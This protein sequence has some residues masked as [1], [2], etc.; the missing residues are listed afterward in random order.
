[1]NSGRILLGLTG[2][3]C[4]G[5]NF[6]GKI[7]EENGFAVLDIDKLGHIALENRK[8][9][10]VE[11]FGDNFLKLDGSI[12]RRALGAYVFSDAD[13]LAVLE[14][15]VHPEVDYLTL[16]WINVHKSVPCVINAALLHRS[17]IFDMLDSV[18]FVKA[19]YIVRMF[20]AKKRDGL[21]W[22]EIRQRFAS[23]Q[24]DIYYSIQSLNIYYINN[25]GFG[26][27]VKLNRR[28]IEKRVNEILSALRD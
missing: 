25:W 26:F 5:K 20:R 28:D 10:I 17:C 13:R 24:F 9:I 16:E 1:M 7:F 15:I 27:F 22:N 14:K 18:V 4:A 8:D 19:P 11:R 21:S 3:Y 6:V 2:L 12:D 23:Q